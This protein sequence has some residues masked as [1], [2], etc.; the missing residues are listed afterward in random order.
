MSDDLLSKGPRAKREAIF[1]ESE[2]SVP[3]DFALKWETREDREWAEI[4]DSAVD[5]AVEET[6]ERSETSDFS[7]SQSDSLS[8]TFLGFRRFSFFFC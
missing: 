6:V 2:I 7:D 8:K 3:D 1:D 5:S 4:A